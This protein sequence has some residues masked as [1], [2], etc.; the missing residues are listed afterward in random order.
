M[1][2]TEQFF[3]AMNYRAIFLIFS[4]INHFHNIQNQL[5]LKKEYKF[6][7]SNVVESS[8]LFILYIFFV[9]ILKQKLLLED[10]SLIIF[11]IKQIW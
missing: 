3:I 7:S 2:K 4:C 9:N 11:F 10:R 6:Q 8:R 1:T 5:F